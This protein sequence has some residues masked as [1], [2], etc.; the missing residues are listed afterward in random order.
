M[1]NI[2]I[3]VLP[4]SLFLSLPVFAED[5]VQ[6]MSDPLAVYTQLGAGYTDKGINLK[7]GRSYDTGSASTMAMNV[8]EIKGIAGEALGWNG[9]A[10]EDNNDSIDSARFRNVQVS[11]KNGRGSQVDINYD[12][13]HEFGTASYSFIQ[14]SPKFGP[15]QLFPLAGLGAAFGN[16]VI[17]DD[18]KVISGYSVP[19][20]F[21][22]VGMYSKIEITDKI[23]F[24]FNPM[25]MTTL[26]GSEL[27]KE[28]GFE[29]DDSVLRQ[30]VALSYQFTPVFNVR[31][32]SNWSDKTDFEDGDHRI[33]FNYQF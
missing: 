25:W 14:A 24:N 8:L 3:K 9:E 27:Y 16:N 26:S 4:L 22:L 5:D 31:Y 10:R 2:L 13:N 17:G 7:V 6:D 15:F 1:S 29:K 30:E 19:G 28:Y 23:W 18:G 11:T 12:F 32:F 21:L 33:E 20:T